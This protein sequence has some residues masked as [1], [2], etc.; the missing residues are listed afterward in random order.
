M[1][2]CYMNFHSIAFENAG[3][4]S[5]LFH[6][7]LSGQEQA[8]VFYQFTPDWHGLEKALAARRKHPINRKA[9]HA[10]LT[11]QYGHIP[12]S[13][14]VAQNIKKLLLPDTF[15]V[16]TGHQLTLG[17]SPLFF[18]YKIA[19]AI[20]LAQQLS[21]KHTDCH[22]V[23]VLWLNSEDH[24]FEEIRHCWFQNQKFSWSPPDSPLIPC[25]ERDLDNIH[26]VFDQLIQAAGHNQTL[27]QVWQSWKDLYI[28]SHNL[29][30]ATRRL[31]HHLFGKHGLV[32]IDQQDLALKKMALPVFRNELIQQLSFHTVSQTVTHLEEAG[33]KPQALPREINLFYS[34]PETGRNRILKTG[35]RFTVLNS[36][37][38]FSLDEFDNGTDTLLPYLSTNV[39]T[40]PLYQ[41]SLL[42]DIATI[43]GPSEVAYWLQYRLMFEKS[44]VFYPVVL[45]R[46][47]FLFISE[48]M[49]HRLQKLGFS[50][51]DL[52]VSPQILLNRWIEKHDKPQDFEEIKQI[53]SE[54]FQLLARIISQSDH[55]LQASAE[56][57]W[58]S[59]ERQIQ[60][61]EK[62]YHRAIRKKHE[63]TAEQIK[64][65]HAWCY[66]EGLFQER[67]THMLDL[68][69]EPKQWISYVISVCN[70]LHATIKLLIHDA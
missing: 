4:G 68:T 44:N 6:D 41:E 34:D 60:K 8:K 2:L 10:A 51:P 54:Q 23:P 55:T 1:F 9:L 16:T 21:E 46:D 43:G 20:A 17:A 70:P 56:A 39:I 22:F 42:P 3:I 18:I 29:T 35:D 15:T 32:I 69:N 27:A 7:Y 37:I 58:R 33:Y 38:S 36:R 67:I 12:L 47:S 52:T 11:K 30:D 31:V 45:M 49:N 53:F 26:L 24:D 64:Q 48:K 28:Q 59:T 61:L 40:R 25:G 62:K 63:L 65:I 19:S 50:Y 14:E 13:A 57:A 66:P 5:P